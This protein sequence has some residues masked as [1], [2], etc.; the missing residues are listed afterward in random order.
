MVNTMWDTLWKNAT[1]VTCEP[2]NEP[3][4]LI[5]Q[6]VIAEKAGKITWVG[7]EAD[8]PKA[9]SELAETVV[10][11]QGRC[12]TPGLID[13]HTHLVYAGNRAHEFEMRLQG[14]TYESI[15][16]AGGGIRSTMM[17]TRQASE[18][19]LLEQSIPRA[20]ALSEQGVTTIEIKSGYGLDLQTELKMLRV[21]RK[22]GE[23]LPLTVKTTFLGAHAIPPEMAGQADRYIDY[24]CDEMLPALVEEKLVDAVDVFCEKIAFSTEQSEKVFQVAQRYHLPVKCH[25]EQLSDM[26][27]SQLA[28]RYRAMSVD[29]LEFLSEAGVKAIAAAGSVAVLLPGAFYFLREK[30]LPP[31]ELLRAHGVP[32]AIATDCNP[33]T[34]PVTSLLLMLNMACTLFRLTPEEALLGVTRHAAQAL[35]MG[36]TQGSLRVGKVADFVVWDVTDPAELAYQIGFNPVVLVNKAG[37]TQYVSK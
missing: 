12:I 2:G 30:Q 5:K 1:L 27:A 11:A 6:A 10:D 31:I 20:Q 26:G 29:H 24:V 16:K 33:G 25:A 19:E 7:R 17:A 4:G 35:G 9:P 21:A 34:S 37:R 8:L 13:C 32:M 15:A 14:A 36:A 3:Y 28:A 23:Q 22:I 18:E